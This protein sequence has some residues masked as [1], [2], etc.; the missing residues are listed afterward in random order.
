M[1]D[2]QMELTLKLKFISIGY[3]YH[4]NTP[5]CVILQQQTL[6]EKEKHYSMKQH[7]LFC[8]GLTYI[9]VVSQLI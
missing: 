7:E 9:K 1:L 5:F 6:H 3:S 4:F 2:G 8:V